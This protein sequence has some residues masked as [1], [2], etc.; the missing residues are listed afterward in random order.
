LNASLV[1][2]IIINQNHISMKPVQE[3]DIMKES[4]AL[5]ETKLARKLVLSGN[6]MVC[7]KE[8]IEN[9]AKELILANLELSFQYKERGD[10]AAELILANKKLAFQNEEKEKR[11]AELVIANIELA[12]QNEEKG[13]RASELIIAN[14]ELVLQ[15]NEKEKRAVELIIANRE[16]AFQKLEKNIRASELVIANKKLIFKTQER[17]IKTAELNIVN[18]DLK[19]AEESQKEY[20]RGLEEMMFMTSHKVRQPIANIIGF[21]DFLDQS[22]NSPD[23]LKKSV[24]CIKESAHTLD[25]F[26]RELTTFIFE[27]GQKEKDQKKQ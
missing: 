13:K 21:S 25:V 1:F 18:R 24:A 14:N 22:I 6:K 19:K 12:Y 23:E 2:V 26:T 20:I 8:E 9:S 16:I 17:E 15:N 5:M 11:A 27:L 3:T 10:L 4:I 7:K